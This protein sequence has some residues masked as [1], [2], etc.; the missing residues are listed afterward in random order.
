[1]I[2]GQQIRDGAAEIP[3]KTIARACAFDHSPGQDWQKQRG[4]ISA[5]L[6]ELADHVVSPVLGVRFPAVHQEVAETL[7]K[8]WADSVG[9][10]IDISFYI[11]FNVLAAEFVHLIAGC[12]AGGGMVFFAS[13]GVAHA[14][15]HPFTGGDFPI[16]SSV[17]AHC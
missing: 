14:Q 4:I 8:I 13:Q 11:I 7:A 16:E 10:H 1:M 2:V 5:T 9:D 17:F 6:T 12:F 15:N 3:K